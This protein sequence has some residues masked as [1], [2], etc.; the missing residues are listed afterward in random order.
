MRM[1]V[2]FSV[3]TSIDLIREEDFDHCLS[4]LQDSHIDNTW[5]LITTTPSPYECHI[6]RKPLGVRS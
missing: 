5:E 1:E 2:L 3:L 6:Y 4:L